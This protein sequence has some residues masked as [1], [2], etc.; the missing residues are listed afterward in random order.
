MIHIYDDVMFTYHI[1]Q[2]FKGKQISVILF[3]ILF[4]LHLTNWNRTSIF[5]LLFFLFQRENQISLHI[6]VE[7]LLICCKGITTTE[8]GAGFLL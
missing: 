2:I 8:Y 6:S 7:L 1:Y 4:L 3:D 5:L